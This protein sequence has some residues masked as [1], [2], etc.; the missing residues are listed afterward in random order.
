MAIALPG[1]LQSSSVQQQQQRLMLRAAS[2]IVSL[3][4]V[5]LQAARGQPYGL[6]VIPIAPA[7]AQYAGSS[8][9]SSSAVCWQ[10]RQQ[11][12]RSMLAAAPAA[13]AQYARSSASSSSAVCSRQ[14][15][16]QQQR[17]ML[18]AAHITLCLLHSSASAPLIAW[19]LWS[20]MLHALLLL[21]LPSC[22]HVQG[23]G[24][25][26]FQGCISYVACILITYLGFAMLRFSN[27]EQKYMRKLDGA[28]RSVSE[29]AGWR[30]TL[31]RGPRGGGGGACRHT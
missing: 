10:Q 25:L 31:G 17:S 3:F 18:A 8:A 21:L 16:Q 4:Q 5:K 14:R 20:S 9:S 6:T 22:C 13:A 30:C 1:K 24:K 29:L 23:N 26:I 11:Q 19:L 2:N 15:Q 7:A 27:I 12:Q 28:A